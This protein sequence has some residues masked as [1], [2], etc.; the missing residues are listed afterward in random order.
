[1]KKRQRPYEERKRKRERETS[2]T[3]SHCLK[4]VSLRCLS[5]SFSLLP[6][7]RPPRY[8][9]SVFSPCPTVSIFSLAHFFIPANSRRRFAGSLFFF[10]VDTIFV[11]GHGPP[12]CNYEA[13]SKMTLAIHKRGDKHERE[14]GR[15]KERERKRTEESGDRSEDSEEQNATRS[16]RMQGYWKKDVTGAMILPK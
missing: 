11:R 12:G 8:S 6:T 5:L 9:F 10:Q 15:E 2:C 1:M 14:R 13:P 3:R 7:F 16:G 4:R